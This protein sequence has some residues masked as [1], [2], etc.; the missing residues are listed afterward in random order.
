MFNRGRP[1]FVS[2]R[3]ED[4]VMWQRA[5]A[6]FLLTLVP[7]THAPAGEPPVPQTAAEL[8]AAFDATAEPLDADVARQW[9]QGDVVVRY[10]LYHVGTFRGD[11]RT[12]RPRMAAYYAFPKAAKRTAAILHLHGGGQRANREY[13]DYWAGLGYAALTINWGEKPLE[14][15][16]FPNTDWD[17]LGAG[18]LDPKHHN[19][20]SPGPNTLH[21]V[22]HP[23]NSSWYLYACAA[24]RG[25]TFLENQPE[26]D[27]ARLGVTGHSM[28]GRLTVLTALD[29]RVKAAVPSVGGSGFLYDDLGG[30]PNSGRHIR[31][32][33]D[34]YNRTIDCRAYWPRIAC[35]VLF[36]GATNDFNSPTELVVK[37]LGL[38]GHDRRRL[39]LAPH[40]NHR[41]TDEAFVARPLWFEAHLRDNFAFPNTARAELDLKTDDGVPLLRVWPDESAAQPIDRVDVYYGYARDPRNRF[42]RDAGAQRVG[43]HWEGRCPVFHLD[44]PLYAFANVIYRLDREVP[45]PRGYRPEVDRLTVSSEYRIAHLED[46]AAAGVR[47]T[48]KPE[49]L[50]DDFSRGWHDW[51][52]IAAANRH[53]WYFGTRK[54]ADPS[55]VGPRGGRLALEVR[56]TEPGNR[57]G[58]VVETD[59]WRGYTGRR[60]DRFVA[61]VPLPEAGWQSVELSAADFENGEGKPLDDWHR[62]TELGFTPADKALQDG[63][64]LEPWKGEIPEFRELRWLGGE[65]VPRPK[66]YLE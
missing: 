53:H 40:L 34:L 59:T 5:T 46:L 32:D 21:G 6:S 3:L 43:D 30:I 66:P 4:R 17:G 16:D 19:D 36:L 52:R 9:E 64:T 58:V 50:I 33:L 22:P 54:I 60:R 65:F 8:W 7:L 45:M 48:E 27:P 49:R 11:R 23:A 47:P 63:E 42:W 44:E 51:L 18:F 62:A 28:G 55:W 2:C 26:V 56:T 20:V 57:L 29:P 14:E 38:L 1:S 25:L 13:A 15:G 61:L 31:A 12:A 10:V 37:G 24:R 41:F 35:P 39:V